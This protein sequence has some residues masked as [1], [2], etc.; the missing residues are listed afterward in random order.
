MELA[1]RLGWKDEFGLPSNTAMECLS[2][3]NWKTYKHALEDLVTWGF[4]EIVQASKN[5]YQSCVIKICPV[6]NDKALPRALPKALIRHE[7]EH[8]SKRS[9]YKYQTSDAI[10][11]PITIK[12]KKQESVNNAPSVVDFFNCFKKE[13]NW[14]D[15]TCNKKAEKFNL[16][17]QN[18]RGSSKL[19]WP[20]QIKS[21]VLGERNNHHTSAGLK[22][23]IC[24][25]I[26]RD[27]VDAKYLN[28]LIGGDR[29]AVINHQVNCLGRTSKKGRN[30]E[31]IRY[32]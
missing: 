23:K 27:E 5:Q 1:N 14:D 8:D 9:E 29:T 12:N 6:T 22:C 15:E 10:I 7:Q 11:K 2:I 26:Q 16:Y 31:F 20:D 21:W 30:G 17:Y 28:S 32:E 24:G 19:D 3:G 18:K 25:L 4:I 13:S